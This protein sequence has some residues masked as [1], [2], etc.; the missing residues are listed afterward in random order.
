MSRVHAGAILMFL[1]IVGAR[2]SA[3]NWPGWRGPRGDGTSS[4]VDVPLRWDGTTGEGI[5]WKTPVPGEGHAS[6]IVWQDHI[7]LPSYLPETTERVLLCFD[8]VTG[9]LRWQRTVVT[10]PP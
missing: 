2:A 6:P 9:Q 1:L 3:E 7:F 10:C 5:V 4:E 8:R